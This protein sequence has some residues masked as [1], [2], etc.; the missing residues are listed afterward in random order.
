MPTHDLA[1]TEP[2]DVVRRQYLASATGDLL[3][4]PVKAWPELAGG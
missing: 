3:F 4:P 2:A 1:A